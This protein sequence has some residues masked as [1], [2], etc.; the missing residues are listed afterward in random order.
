MGKHIK[1]VNVLCG[2]AALLI[3][4]TFL[5]PIWSLSAQAVQYESEFPEGLKVYV[6]LSKIGGDTDELN[7]M[8]KWIGAHFPEKVPEMVIFP[9]LF[10]GLALV[11]LA[12]LFFN[13]RKKSVLALALIYFSLLVLSGFTSLQWRLYAF[14]HFRDP[15]PPILVPDFTIPLLGSKK[16]WNWTIS[17]RLDL[18]AFTLGLAALSLALAYALNATAF[19]TKEKDA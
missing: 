10:A 19:R 5:S 18:G 2:G 15:N 14:G 8:N 7:L 11:C 1:L 16:L 3:I 6:Y 12:A 9:V 4:A 13:H 17:T